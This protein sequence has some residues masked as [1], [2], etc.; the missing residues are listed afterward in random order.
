MK[1]CFYRLAMQD[2][3]PTDTPPIQLYLKM[4]NCQLSGAFKIRGVINQITSMMKE[5]QDKDRKDLH[6]V[7]CS[8]GICKPL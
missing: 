6:F 5:H 4:E 3:L 2:V 7:C 8:A 1:M